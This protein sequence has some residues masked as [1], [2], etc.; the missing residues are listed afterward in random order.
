MKKKID[1]GVFCGLLII[2]VVVA[3]FLYL[4]VRYNNNIHDL[5]IVKYD[6]KSIVFDDGMNRKEVLKN[7]IISIDLKAGKLV[8]LY[9]GRFGYTKEL[10]FTPIISENE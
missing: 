3:V 1:Y 6:N 10:R 5:R 4:I 7:R 8:Y 2:T 9:D